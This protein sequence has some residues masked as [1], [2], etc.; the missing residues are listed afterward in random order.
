MRGGQAGAGRFL[1]RLRVISH[2][3]NIGDTRSM[4]LHPATSTHTSFSQELR[5]RLGISP[6]L[7]RLSVGIEDVTDLINDLDRALS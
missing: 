4:A 2:M 6:G 5:D 7:I 3:T 1:D